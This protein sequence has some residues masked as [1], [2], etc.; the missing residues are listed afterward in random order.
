MKNNQ[1]RFF[2]TDWHG[3]IK[4]VEKVFKKCNFDFN[5]DLL[6][7][8]GDVFDRGKYSFECVEFLSKIKNLVW[9]EG[10]H[11][12]AFKELIKTNNVCLWLY[13]QKET[14]KSYFK[15]YKLSKYEDCVNEKFSGV[16]LNLPK[17]LVPD[18]HLNLLNKTLNYFELDG[19]LFIHAGLDLEESIKT[20]IPDVL[21][22]DRNFIKM[23]IKSKKN[24]L[25][26][27]KEVYLGHTPTQYF[28][29]KEI[30]VTDNVYLCD[31]GAGKYENNIV[32][33]INIDTKEIF[34]SN[35]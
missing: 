18:K 31:T 12:W 10:N 24:P 28:N 21:M 13:G 14:L 1:K 29:S 5:N 19:K 2:S 3:C 25:P 8:G 34:Y 32:S 9:I 15:H 26:N 4:E 17:N 35:K 20:Q 11:D 23:V 16:S 30:I 7:F 33:I 22:W 6:I 27:Y